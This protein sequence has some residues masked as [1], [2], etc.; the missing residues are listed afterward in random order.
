M[1]NKLERLLC[2][3]MCVGIGFFLWQKEAVADFPATMAGG[4]CVMNFSGVCQWAPPNSAT[5]EDACQTVENVD[6]FER[7][8][9]WNGEPHPAARCGFNSQSVF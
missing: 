9:M 4:Y 6:P 7:D 2:A 3:F 8:W 5:L 1:L